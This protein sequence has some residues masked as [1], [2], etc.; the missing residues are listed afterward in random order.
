MQHNAANDLHAVMAQAEHTV[1]RLA[2]GRKRFR[3]QI[4]QAFAALIAL[5]EFLGF[6]AQLG[7]GQ[8]AVFIL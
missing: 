1:S 5:F 3:Q 8:F 4:V 6:G 2:A 7:V